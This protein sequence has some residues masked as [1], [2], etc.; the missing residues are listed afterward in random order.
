MALL[1][2]ARREGE[3]GSAAAAAAAWDNPLGGK[4]RDKR[5]SEEEM[6]LLS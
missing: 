1:F 4:G 5:E 2:P 6:T 3:L